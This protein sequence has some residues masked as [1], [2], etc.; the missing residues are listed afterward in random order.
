MRLPP[1]YSRGFRSSGMLSS[2]GWQMVTDVAGWPTRSICKF[3][4]N[5]G[6][7][8]PCKW[9]HLSTRWE[10]NGQ[11]HVP[12]LPALTRTKNWY[13]L[14]RTEE[15]YQVWCVQLRAIVKPRQGSGPG[16]LS[17]VVSWKWRKYVLGR[18]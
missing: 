9:E 10:V 14:N 12:R 6:L 11:R 15:S 8:D 16:P 1:Q 17:A 4:A 3:Q 7:L 13:L 2:V 5:S 18:R